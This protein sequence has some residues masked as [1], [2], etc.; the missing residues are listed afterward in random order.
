M[1]FFCGESLSAG[2][3]LLEK[4]ICLALVYFNFIDKNLFLCYELP[5][6]FFVNSTRRIDMTYRTHTEIDDM[7]RKK[8][9]TLEI[10]LPDNRSITL[11]ELK[12]IIRQQ[13]G[14]VDPRRVFLHFREDKLISSR[15]IKSY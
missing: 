10:D 6:T 1:N 14:W 4:I 3:P 12:T 8:T 7:S 13:L 9:I 2:H 5:S 11:F 15:T